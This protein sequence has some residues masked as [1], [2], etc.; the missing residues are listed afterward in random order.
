MSFGI[1]WIGCGLHDLGFEGHN[2]TWS[3][4]QSCAGNIQERLDR[5]VATTSW[6][7]QFRFAKVSHLTRVLFDHCALW[8][9]WGEIEPDRGKRKRV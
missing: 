3:N 2:F 1:V 8:I 4:K 6:S 9:E 7:D 5:G